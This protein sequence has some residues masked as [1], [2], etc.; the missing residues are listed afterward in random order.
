MPEEI[1]EKHKKETMNVSKVALRQKSVLQPKM[2]ENDD[3]LLLV[4]MYVA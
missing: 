3:A 4:T 1:R 2:K